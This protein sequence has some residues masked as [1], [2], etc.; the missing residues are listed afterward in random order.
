MDVFP[1]GAL[2]FADN[3]AFSRWTTMQG[4]S[5][6]PQKKEIRNETENA[7]NIMI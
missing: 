5:K 7:G 2:G 6:I 4:K 1:V 3:G